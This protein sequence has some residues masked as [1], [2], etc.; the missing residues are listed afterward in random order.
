MTGK[1]SKVTIHPHYV[2]DKRDQADIALVSVDEYTTEYAHR[3]MIW[4]V[5]FLSSISQQILQMTCR[6]FCIW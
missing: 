1:K 3:S 6:V 2:K 5:I 4:I